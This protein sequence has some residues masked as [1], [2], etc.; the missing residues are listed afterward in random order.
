MS[1]AFTLA[2]IVARLG[3]EGFEGGRRLRFNYGQIVAILNNLVA[4]QQVA[5]A[6]AGGGRVPASFILQE[7][8]G[9]NEGIEGAPVI[10][11]QGRPQTD[12][13]RVGM[14]K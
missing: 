2:E 4:Q 7:L 9:A 10:P 13:G 14:A 8:P 1:R 5:A 11:D 3:G 6:V 12:D